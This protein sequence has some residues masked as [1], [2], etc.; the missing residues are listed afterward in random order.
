[1]LI[2][3]LSA[4]VVLVVL[5]LV[6]DNFARQY[7]T[8][9]IREKVASSLGL[10]SD[11]PVT[12]KLSSGSILLQ[13]ATGHINSVTITIDPLTLNGLSGSA[14]LTGHDVPLSRTQ[15]VT[16][17]DAVVRIPAATVRAAIA[18]LPGLAQYDPKVT[19]SG[20]HAD[21]TAS[22]AILGFT[23]SLG[24]TLTRFARPLDRSD[25]LRWREHLHRAA[26]P[27]CPESR[28]G[29][30]DRCLALHRGPAA[31]IPGSYRRGVQG[32]DPRLDVHRRRDRIEFRV[33][34]RKGDLPGLAFGRPIS[35]TG[36]TGSN[37]RV[38]SCRS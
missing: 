5:F 35:L 6:A 23:Q 3:I 33:S 7:A 14:T 30:V 17:L 2:A 28:R 16:S 20:D 32:P 29:A 24:I 38:F 22:I 12:V 9:Y 26:C 34:R 19:I 1:V 15:P 27:L 21:V 36:L 37:P 10:A 4:V 8:H 18:K 31:Q 25:H 13:A 11:A